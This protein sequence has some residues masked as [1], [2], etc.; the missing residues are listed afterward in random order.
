[1]F[2]YRRS[3]RA[4]FLAGALTLCPIA[5]AAAFAQDREPAEGATA[6]DRATSFKAVSGAVKEDVPGGPLLVIA[7]GFVWVAVLGYVL[8]LGRLQTRVE[9]SLGDLERALQKPHVDKATDASAAVSP[10]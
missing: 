2:S 9:H 7:Y 5:I 10:G 3:S 6:G 4:L 1:M 8:R